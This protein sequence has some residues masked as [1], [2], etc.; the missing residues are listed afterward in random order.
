MMMTRDYV[1]LVI[2][3]IIL[4]V[5]MLLLIR[6]YIRYDKYRKHKDESH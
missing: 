1:W 6:D 5:V 2:A 3:I 4:I